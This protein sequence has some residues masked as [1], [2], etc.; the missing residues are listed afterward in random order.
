MSNSLTNNFLLG[1]INLNDL[2]RLNKEVSPPSLT[3]SKGGS[4]FVEG[5]I[6]NEVGGFDP[7]LF[8]GYAAE[9]QIFWDKVSTITNIGYS[10]NPCIDM[11]HMW[12][13][14]THSTNPFL[15]VME[16]YMHEFRSMNNENKLKF[17]HLKRDYFNE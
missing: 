5:D 3:G 11:F 6:F 8:W 1:Q 9:D 2:D 7:E 17:L 4:I 15:F 12:H 10:D 13:E 14:P 16:N